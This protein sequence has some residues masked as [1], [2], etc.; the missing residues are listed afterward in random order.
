MLTGN[1][2]NV[3]N[4]TFYATQLIVCPA[5]VISIHIFTLKWIL[6][7]IWYSNV[8]HLITHSGIQIK[9]QHVQQNNRK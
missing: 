6:G 4:V 8:K 5:Q 7:V 1:Y 3:E 2:H 9:G